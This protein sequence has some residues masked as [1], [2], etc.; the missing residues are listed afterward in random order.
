MRGLNAVA[1][2]TYTLCAL[3]AT[4][5][6]RNDYGNIFDTPGMQLFIAK[7]GSKLGQVDPMVS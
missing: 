2:T 4:A 3:P 6:P 7:D 1:H 5:Q